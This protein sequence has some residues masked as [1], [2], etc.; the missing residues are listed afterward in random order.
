[1]T[2]RRVRTGKPLLPRSE[3]HPN[4]PT[5]RVPMMFD[6]QRMVFRC[7]IEG[8]KRVAWPKE[9]VYEKAVVGTGDLSLVIS[10]DQNKAWLRTANNV[11]IELP[12]S[13]PMSEDENVSN[14]FHQYRDASGRMRWWIK[15]GGLTEVIELG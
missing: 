6:V 7:N 10:K 4:C 11:M 8:C 15:I 1:M 2:V 9:E 3:D 14:L 13:M 12:L 5:H